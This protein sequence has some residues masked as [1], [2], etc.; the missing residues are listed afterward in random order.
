MFKLSNYVTQEQT[1]RLDSG[2]MYLREI[3]N[4][5]LLATQEG[6]H[7]VLRQCQVVGPTWSNLDNFLGTLSLH[8]NTLLMSTSNWD[9]LPNDYNDA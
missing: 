1:R 9:S 6:G 3:Y 8:S 4:V 2:R 5:L 7:H